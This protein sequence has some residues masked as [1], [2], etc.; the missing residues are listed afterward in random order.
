M[1]TLPRQ[2]AYYFLGLL[3]T[4]KMKAV[5]SSETV[6]KLYQT[7]RYNIRENSIFHTHVSKNLKSHKHI[8]KCLK[9]GIEMSTLLLPKP[10]TEHSPEPVP[11]SSYS[12]NIFP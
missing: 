6:V 1:L 8:T 9:A 12:H 2:A 10:A 11:S 3:L 5:R 4:T 7:T